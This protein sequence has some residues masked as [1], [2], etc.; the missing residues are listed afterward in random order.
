MRTRGV[1]GGDFSIFRPS[2]GPGPSLSGLIPSGF[3]TPY[4]E[5]L[6]GY[7]QHSGNAYYGK[8]CLDGPTYGVFRVVVSRVVDG[9]S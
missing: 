6:S 8:R 7:L 3:D 2:L 4:A 5:S 1:F 9:L